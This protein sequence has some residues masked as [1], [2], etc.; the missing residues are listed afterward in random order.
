[1]IDSR[2]I[3]LKREPFFQIAKN[4]IKES[5]RVLDI[6]PGDGEF[7]FYCNKEDIYLFDR[8]EKTVK[9]LKKKYKNVFLGEL[10]KLPFDSQFF[11]VIHISHV[12]EHLYPH[13]LYE[14]L[15][16]MNRCCKPGG[17]IIISTPLLWHG[18]YNDLSHIRPYNPMVIEKYLC[19]QSNNNFSRKNISHDFTVERIEYRYIEKPE[20][21]N[22]YKFTKIGW[23][24]KRIWI[25]CRRRLF[26]KYI[27]TGYTIV[28][29]KESNN[30]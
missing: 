1:M 15:N 3:T 25:F 8:N 20:D 23:L 29:R 26:K 19:R 18:F 24:L 28:L 10:P 7:A 5:Y 13:Q 17:F 21:L 6:G 9:H 14:S 27:K 11:D 12:I 22:L 30:T 2:Y 16:E 4:L